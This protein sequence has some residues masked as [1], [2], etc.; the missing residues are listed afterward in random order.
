M[1]TGIHSLT[2]IG[3][4]LVTGAV[5]AC[6]ALKQISELANAETLCALIAVAASMMILR[7][8][9]PARPRIFRTALWWLTGSFAILVR[10]YLFW[11]LPG[12]TQGRF[13]I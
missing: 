3:A 2:G 11:N 4:G 12:I 1:G 13:F 8:H 10:I 6:A 9:E 5:C 7:L